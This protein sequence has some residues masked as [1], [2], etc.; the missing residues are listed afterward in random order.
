MKTH[1][2]A[3]EAL[4][5]V[6]Q[7][8]QE[9]MDK[10]DARTNVI[11]AQNKMQT[12]N[13]YAFLF[14]TNLSSIIKHYDLTKREIVVVLK[15]IEYMY[16]GNLLSF[17]NNRLAEDLNIDKANISRIL[18]R[19]KKTELIVEDNGNL[20]FNPHIA[21]KGTLDERKPD[22][23]RLIDYSAIVL[24]EYNSPA[25][26]SIATNNIRRKQRKDSKTS[27]DEINKKIKEFFEETN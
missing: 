11:V 2:N 4:A 25:T 19:L 27:D 26:V 6:A 12:I 7:N 24:D 23:C 22:D 15:L 14:A 10:K 5:D 18:K 17:S 9:Q 16:F 8:L 13:E 20:Y 21:C 1:K 3:T